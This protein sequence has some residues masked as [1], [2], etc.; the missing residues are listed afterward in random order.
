[1]NK[2]TRTYL[3][4]LASDDRE[5][6]HQAFLSLIKETDQPVEWTYEVW[7]EMVMNLSHENN[8]Q[9]AIAAQL[10]CNLAKSDPR[11]QMRNAF[12]ALLEVTRDERFVTARHTIQSLWK[13]GAA[14]KEQ[15][16]LFL[17]GVEFRFKEC[18]AEKNCTLIRYDFLQGLRTLYD[19]LQDQEIKKLAKELIE[20]ESELKYQKKYATLWNNV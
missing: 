19:Q 7:D 1:M 10:L 18:A 6:Q 4:Q 20:I 13:V 16:Q 2:T 5:L 17:E 12:P 9:R 8:R 14:G 11:N 3:D 15:L